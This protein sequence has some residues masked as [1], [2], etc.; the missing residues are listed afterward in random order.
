LSSKH[1]GNSGSLEERSR[2]QERADRILDAAAELVGRWG[3]KK[4]TVDDIARQAGVAK[5]TIYLHWKTREDLFIALRRREDLKL[6][7]DIRQR[8]ANDP[9]GSTLRGF[10]KHS[11]LALMKRPL[12]KALFLNDSEMFG[13]WASREY[14]SA[15]YQ[16]RIENYKNLLEFLRGQGVVRT[17]MGIREQTFMLGAMWLGFLLAGRWMPEEFKFADGEA[18]EMLAEAV[19]RT[20]AADCVKSGTW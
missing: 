20:L 5:G 9:A 19:Q 11:T 3:Y 18:V 16:E 12:M 10:V 4:T 1:D 8:I 14:S 6:A 17:D 15:T 7:E 2:R 13:E